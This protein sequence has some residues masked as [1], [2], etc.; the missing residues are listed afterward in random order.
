MRSMKA[1]DLTHRLK[2]CDDAI[3]ALYNELCDLP[4]Q[5]VTRLEALMRMSFERGMLINA[6]NKIYIHRLL[7]EGGN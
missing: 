4:D 5:K 6:M 1:D 7:S 3:I 2:L